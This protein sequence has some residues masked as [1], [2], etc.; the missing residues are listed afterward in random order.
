MPPSAYFMPLLELPNEY[1][2]F[3]EIPTTPVPS[4]ST[5]SSDSEYPN[6]PYSYYGGSISSPGSPTSS[7]CT[8]SSSSHYLESDNE[9]DQDKIPSNPNSPAWSSADLPLSPSHSSCSSHKTLPINLKEIPLPPSPTSPSIP[10]KSED[11]IHYDH[12][13]VACCNNCGEFPGAL[14]VFATCS[15]YICEDCAGEIHMKCPVPKCQKNSTEVNW[16]FIPSRMRGQDS[17][18]GRLLSA[19]FH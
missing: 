7:D 13:D 9:S 15:H 12:D 10:A 4:P 19:L 16:L 2:E 6:S 3:I 18:V 5:S 17:T 14:L 8:S 11:A 1:E